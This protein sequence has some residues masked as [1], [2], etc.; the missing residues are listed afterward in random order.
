[1][2]NVNG[3]KKEDEEKLDPTVAQVKEKFGGLRFYCD[4]TD[5]VIDAFIMFAEHMSFGICAACGTNQNVTTKGRWRM[6]L[7]GKCRSES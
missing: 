4:N 6:S 5:D 3:R 7:C 2:K 1:M